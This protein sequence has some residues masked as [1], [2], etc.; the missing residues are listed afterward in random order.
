MTS[1]I[2]VRNVSLDFPIY[3]AESRSLRNMAL[4]FGSAG[5]MKNSAAGY[6]VV[7]ALR[8]I[9]FELH[10][11]DQFGLLG[12]NGAGKTTLLKLIAGIYS[13]TRGDLLRQGM[14][15][16]LF[17]LGLGMEED[18]T[19]LENIFL[20]SYL[21]GLPKEHIEEIVDEIIEFTG[22][23]DFINLP[24]RVYSAGMRTRLAFAISTAFVP[25]ILL[26]D[27]VFGA[28]DKDFIEKSNT[29]MRELMQS[30]RILVFSTHS[31]DLL[32]QF[33]NKGLYLSD[34]KVV[35]MGDI[36][37]VIEAYESSV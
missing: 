23:Q 33:C 31:N 2:I 20:A 15:T 26:I 5:R 6:M 1:S 8:D 24:I 19:G 16:T 28:G 7:E 9:S 37:E 10:Q 17:D 25:D 34:G 29:R 35:C 21:R 27:E 11:G 13:P 4:N 18:A 36:E 3:S 22:L 32:R 12:P 14:V 30:A